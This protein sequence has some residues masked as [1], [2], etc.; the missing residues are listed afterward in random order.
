MFQTISS[1]DHLFHIDRFELVPDLPSDSK[2]SLSSGILVSAKG[3]FGDK[4]PL[5]SV[6][7]VLDPDLFGSVHL[8]LLYDNCVNLSVIVFNNGKLKVSGG[9]PP[10]VASQADLVSFI[11][12]V[13]SGMCTWLN[14]HLEGLPRITCLNGIVRTGASHTPAELRS[15]IQASAHN[16]NRVVPPDLNARGG[17]RSAFKCYLLHDRKLHIAYDHKGVGQVFAARSLD[18]ILSCATALLPKKKN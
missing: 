7:G 17:R 14:L 12:D 18:E 3:S 5:S 10:H 15:L 13:H 9:T 6:A 4:A 16:F 8:K 1:F 2:L 11:S